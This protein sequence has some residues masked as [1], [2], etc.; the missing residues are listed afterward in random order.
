[1]LSINQKTIS[2]ALQLVVNIIDIQE[3]L[4]YSGVCLSPPSLTL[5]NGPNIIHNEKMKAAKF[6]PI[7]NQLK[8]CDIEL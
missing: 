3:K 7:N 5:A 1:M 2:P 4:L 8:L 6:A